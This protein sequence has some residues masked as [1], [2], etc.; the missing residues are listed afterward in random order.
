MLE[1][2]EDSKDT[3]ECVSLPKPAPQAAP[4]TMK[5][6]RY[7][8]LT[9]A[10]K[11]AIIQ[12]VLSGRPQVEVAREFVS[13][14]AISDY[15]KNKNKILSATETSSRSEQKKVHQGFHPQLEEALS[16]WL[17]AN[18]AQRVPVSGHLLKQKAETLALCLGIDGFNSFIMAP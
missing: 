12:Q 5:R 8:T 3:E 14:Q 13:K 10:K 18:V 6:S 16:I 2:D 17:N 11:A 15:M 4:T 1:G 7:A 9:M